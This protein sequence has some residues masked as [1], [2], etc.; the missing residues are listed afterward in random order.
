LQGRVEL[1]PQWRERCVAALHRP[2]PRIELG[3]ALRPLAHAVIDVSD[4][5]LADLGHILERSAVSALLELEA[6]PGTALAATADAELGRTCLL[7]G[8]DDYELL[9]TAAPENDAAIAALGRRL[10]LPLTAIGEIGGGPAGE[11]RLVDGAGNALRLPPA[12]FDHFA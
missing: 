3:L 4:G 6:L 10:G 7:G 11:T 2:E 12:G 8:G 1:A 5:L 9:F